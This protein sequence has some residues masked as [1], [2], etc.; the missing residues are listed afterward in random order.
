MTLS[1][2]TQ[3]HAE[4]AQ[5]RTDKELAQQAHLA[6]AQEAIA[7][8]A[9]LAQAHAELE[10]EYVEAEGLRRQLATLQSAIDNL[11]E[12]QD[13]QIDMEECG[14]RCSY[15][16]KF[17][18]WKDTW[19]QAYELRYDSSGAAAKLLERLA[20]LDAAEAALQAERQLRREAERR[21]KG[22][23]ATARKR[24]IQMGGAERR[25]NKAIKQLIRAGEREH[26]SE[27]RAEILQQE[28]SRWRGD[29]ESAMAELL[30]IRERLADA[31][32]RAERAEA[33]LKETSGNL[34]RMVELNEWSRNELDRM[35]ERAEARVASTREAA[36]WLWGFW[37]GNTLVAKPGYEDDIREAWGGLLTATDSE[38]ATNLL[39][40][41]EGAEALAAL[42]TPGLAEMLERLAWIAAAEKYP[43]AAGHGREFATRIRE[44]LDDQA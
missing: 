2:A 41:L 19:E 4:L 9:E 16:S 38:A 8:R 30:N 36:E 42:V 34:R 33:D 6:A 24:A 13:R 10:S 17:P 14:A 5:A 1:A 37:D 18:E 32:Q 26:Q 11:C 29:W 12:Q 28:C 20:T 7:L 35:V 43:V 39:S 25:A 31:E 3:L 40:R 27:Q 15:P 22:A 44:V 23:L 21:A